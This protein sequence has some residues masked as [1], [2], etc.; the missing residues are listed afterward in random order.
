MPEIRVLAPFDFGRRRLNGVGDITRIGGSFGS[1]WWDI[2]VVVWDEVQTLHIA[3][4]MPLPLA[5]V[6]PD[7]FLLAWFYLSG[8]CSPGWFR[9]YSRRA[10]KRLCVGVCVC[11]TRQEAQQLLGVADRTAS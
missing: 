3:Q 7:W 4:Q 5:P 10:V 9:T 2:G 8:T 11:V 6:N 1:E